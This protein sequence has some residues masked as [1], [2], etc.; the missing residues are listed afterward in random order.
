MKKPF[1]ISGQRID[2]GETKTIYLDLART[3]DRSQISLPVHVIRGVKEGPTLFVS[4]AI[5]GDEINGVEII[6]RLIKRIKP[7][8]LQG[9]LIAVPV[10]NVFGFNMAIRYLPDRRDLNRSFPGSPSGSLAGRIANIFM[11]EVVNKSTHGI[12]LHTGAVHRYNQPQIRAC[13]DDIETK[14]LA[15][16]FGVPV[17]LNSDLRDGSLREAARRKKIPMLLFEGGEALRFNESVIRVGWRGILSVM[18]VI[19]MVNKKRKSEVKSY[20][21][22]ESMWIRSPQSGLMRCFKSIGA[23]VR[24]GDSLGVISGPLGENSVYFEAPF[25]GIIIGI[26]LLPLISQGDATIHI[27]GFKNTKNVKKEVDIFDSELLD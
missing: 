10:V 2:L 15:E 23:H 16:S 20:I 5:H 26:N 7:K 17:I 11:K 1:K 8:S 18:N 9:T 22:R 4:A 19:G 3:F 13:L 12:D 6:K 25:D 21:A 24:E 27:A 14:H